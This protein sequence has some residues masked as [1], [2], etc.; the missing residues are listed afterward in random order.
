MPGF[1]VVMLNLALSIMGIEVHY[2]LVVFLHV[3]MYLGL[4]HFVV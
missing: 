2:Q 3:C 1:K 4:L